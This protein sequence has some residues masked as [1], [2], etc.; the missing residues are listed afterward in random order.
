[1]EIQLQELFEQIKEYDTD[2]V[3]VIGGSIVYEQLLPYCSTAYV[4]KVNTSKPA[5]KYFPNLDEM[6]EWSVVSESED[7]TAIYRG[8]AGVTGEITFNFVEYVRK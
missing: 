1:M 4:T 2:S 8:A 5:D 3:Y 6:A 7:I